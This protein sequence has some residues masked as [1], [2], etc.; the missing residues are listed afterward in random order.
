MS[1]GR[2]NTSVINFG[3]IIIVAVLFFGFLFY[4]NSVRSAEGI[5]RNPVTVS[6][7][8]SDMSAVFSPCLRIHVFQKTWISNRD[9]FSLLA[10]NRNPLSESRKT[11]IIAG[12]CKIVLQ[13]YRKI[14]QF[15][16]LYHEYPDDTGEPPLPC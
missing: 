12:H 14:P 15:I 9:N 4:N 10:F 5:N 7:T 1:S 2:S 16:L 6:L 3:T 11:G 8:L 13:A